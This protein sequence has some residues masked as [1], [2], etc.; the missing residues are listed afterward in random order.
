M[1]KAIWTGLLLVVAAGAAELDL[2]APPVSWQANVDRGGTTI[3]PVTA[4]EGTYAVEIHTDGGDE[5][6]PK[7]GRFWDEPQDWSGFLRVR[8][9]VRVTCSDPAVRERPLQLIFYDENVRRQDLPDHPM[10]QQGI[11]RS[12]PVGRWCEFRNTLV[13]GRSAIRGFVVYLYELPP[14]RPHTCRWEFAELQLEGMDGAHEVFDMELYPVAALAAQPGA[15]QASVAT[16]DGL[17][18]AL[19][20]AGRV[21]AVSLDG[22]TVSGPPDRPGGLLVRDAAAFGEPV[23]VAGSLAGTEVGVRQRAELPEQ[24]LRVETVWRSVGPAIEVVGTVADTRGEDRAVTVYVAIPLGAGDWTWWDSV[25]APRDGVNAA[26]EL[27]Y[28]EGGLQYGHQGTHSKYPFGTVSCPEVGALSLAVRMDEPVVHRIFWHPRLRLLVCALDLGLVPESNHRGESL[29]QA[30]FRV[31]L[32]RSDPRWGFRSALQ[33]YYDLFPEFFTKRVPS[34]GGWY[35][36]GSVADTPGAVEAGFGCH[37]GPNGLDA[38]R[39]DREHGLLSFLYIEPELYQQTHGDAETAP[40]VEQGHE[41]LAGLA[42]GDPE[43]VEAF[44]RLGYSHSYVPGGWRRHHS[45]AE[46]VQVVARAALVSGLFD[47]FGERVCSVGQMPWMSESKWGVLYPCNLDPDIPEGKGWFA[48][49]VYLL[50]ELAA[51]AEA[52]AAYDGVGL[53]SFGGF[54]IYA[55]ADFRREN[56]RYADT[57]LSFSA[58]DYR[59]VRVASFGSVEWLRELAA[60]L[61][62]Q[63]KYLMTNC[64]WNITPGWLCFAAPYLDVLG[65]EAPAFADPD[66]AR[67]IAY[68]KTLTDLPYDPRPETEMAR[69]LVHAIFPGHGNDLDLMKRYAPA[70]RALAAAGW[71]PVTLATAKPQTVRLERYGRDLLVVAPTGGE[72]MDAEITLDSALGCRAGRAVPLLGGEPLAVREG[73]LQVHLDGRPVVLRLEPAAP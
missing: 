22:R 41:R 25:S 30:P 57:P 49:E 72:P 1:G 50:P 46:A 65:A 2:L 33:R 8:M 40:T 32:Y 70:F 20:E 69:N 12:V 14:G 18:V 23:V 31:L 71:E 58:T 17:A 51:A 39:W 11:P 28:L 67:A 63:G 52:G 7:F 24:G 53:D 62:G 55:R 6:Y 15:A 29:S 27:A 45:H 44:C 19:D 16:D 54:G 66:F 36:W 56:Y 68:R 59:P 5:D 42:A 47:S 64:S 73:R 13:V 10:T 4:D 48:R 9:K 60:L 38:V 3:T 61:H 26:T 21:T 37:W 35:V 43:T 34:E